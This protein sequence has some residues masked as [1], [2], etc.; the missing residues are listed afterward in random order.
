MAMQTLKPTFKL[1]LS[2]GLAH[3]H[4]VALWV[5]QILAWLWLGHI[6][7]HLG[8]SVASGVGAVAVWWVARIV[9]RDSPWAARCP[10]SMVLLLGASSAGLVCALAYG[11][12]ALATHG[13]LLAL[14]A[15]WGVWCAVMEAQLHSAN[16]AC[17]DAG[18][19]SESESESESEF[20][21]EAKTQI[22]TQTQ[23]QSGST[24]AMWPSAV[25]A[26]V[27][28]LLWITPVGAPGPSDAVAAALL[29]CGVLWAFGYQHHYKQHQH[30]HQ[31]H[32]RL[33]R[34]PLDRPREG[35]WPHR[36]L[37]STAMGLMMGSLWLGSEW[38]ASAGLTTGESVA[39]HVALMAVLP[40]G[41]GVW[42]AMY[43]RMVPSLERKRQWVLSLLALGAL[44]SM[45]ASPAYGVWAM[46]LPSLAWALDQHQG[47]AARL[48]RALPQ[49]MHAPNSSRTHQRAPH[50]ARQRDQV[51]GV[52]GLTGS[53]L[54]ALL[55]GPG[56]LLLVGVLSPSYG[57]QA[58]RY[59]VLVVGALAA[60]CLLV[61]LLKPWLLALRGQPRSGSLAPLPKPMKP[62]V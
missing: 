29:V 49:H 45:S 24:A 47:S 15:M 7:M 55:L 19:H 30:Q 25:A 37:P 52:L 38:C 20:E 33:G 34:A 41:L 1:Q 27:V 50:D 21:S 60:L 58:M 36:V 53:V 51:N 8:W 48:Q 23:T 54:C 6:G 39:V 13:L 31:H 42:F 46:L 18:A 4:A 43:P 32:Q 35:H 16:R 44:I 2:S 28:G 40:T 14:A 11:P 26:A 17:D 57:P 5:A 61:S 9:L 56:L 3:M 62:N 22:K 59:A 12:S 10:A